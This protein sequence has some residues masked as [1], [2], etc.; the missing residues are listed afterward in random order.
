MQ[1]DSVHW[2]TYVQTV[3]VIAS[4]IGTFLYVYFTYHIMKWA[5][6]QG[7]VSVQQTELAIAEMSER[8]EA[9]DAGVGVS[10]MLDCARLQRLRSALRTVPLCDPWESTGQPIAKI[11]ELHA[12]WMS[13]LQRE[14]P[15]EVR[16][17]LDVSCA[18]LVGARLICKNRPS[19]EELAD[20][21]LTLLGLLD[22]ASADLE[23]L[24]R[25]RY[26]SQFLN[27]ILEDD[28]SPL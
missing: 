24:V 27:A 3:A 5:I 18:M 22:S 4:T 11:E 26:E 28:W 6:D 25:E 20:R 13:L 7:K 12:R 8:R 23:A 10:L 19:D 9:A 17:V 16:R 14:L 1:S 15:R 2:T 21:R